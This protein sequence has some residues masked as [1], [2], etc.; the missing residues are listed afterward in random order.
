MKTVA[1]SLLS[2]LAL[3]TALNASLGVCLALPA[4]AVDLSTAYARALDYDSE[5]AG[6]EAGRNVQIENTALSRSALMPVVAAGGSVSH[7]DSDPHRL[8]DD[9]YLNK[10]VQVSVTQPLLAMDALYT[11][12][13]SKDN[14]LKADQ[15]LRL[16]RQDLVSRTANA[17]FTVLRG[18]DDLETA[19]KAEA[20]FR[21]QWEQAKERFE[22]GQYA[23]TEVHET[24]AIYDSGRVTRIN[25]Q[26]QLDVAVE[27]LQRIT[28]E[29]IDSIHPLDDKYG[30]EN[31]DPGI[32]ADLEQQAAQSSP[33]IQAAVWQ[34][35]SARKNL[36]A[37]K[38]GYY[39]T[40]DLDASIGYSD[41][42]GPS[43]EDRQTDKVIGLNLNVPIYLGGSTQAGARQARFQVDQAEQGLLTVQRN[44]RL[45]LRSLYR[46]VQTNIEAIQAQRQQIVSTLSALEATQAGYT[47]GTRNIVE[48]LDAERKYY[49]A[50]S[51]YANARYDYI[52][53]RLALR[54]TIGVLDKADL[55]LLNASLTAPVRINSN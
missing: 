51:S 7:T 26:G 25:A 29:F 41:Y 10:G 11:Y 6:A 55:D 1:R 44:V 34:L 28:G 48:V 30:L 21:R 18:L 42:E 16:A 54:E 20:A 33:A 22:V 24:K 12:R 27:A 49:V 47:V 8:P 17:Y 4:Y 31:T 38:A 32:L 43:F 19:K 13:A 40:L 15:D 35:E 9:S 50:L 37:K 36:E 45:Q 53:N 2:P 14:E 39:P 23:I 46:A 52:I 3:A 5:L